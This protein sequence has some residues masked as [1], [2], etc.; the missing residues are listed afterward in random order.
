MHPCSR[1]YHFDRLLIETNGS[2]KRTDE[3]P[4]KPFDMALAVET[5][6]Q[7]RYIPVAQVALDNLRRLA[8]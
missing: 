8:S 2:C 3:R 5:L 6:A 4:S 7:L 1:L